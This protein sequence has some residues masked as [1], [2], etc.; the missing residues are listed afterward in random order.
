MDFFL[1]LPLKYLFSTRLYV[2]AMHKHLFNNNRALL[3]VERG[4][5]V[6]K[7]IFNGIWEEY[8]TKIDYM[9][10]K[11]RGAQ[12]TIWEEGI[13]WKGLIAS[14]KLPPELESLDINYGIDGSYLFY[15]INTALFHEEL[16]G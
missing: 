9:T 3:S 4:R 13:N 2:E 14:R 8:R 1:N 7:P 16:L 11:E 5:K 15:L 6:Q 10:Q 12:N